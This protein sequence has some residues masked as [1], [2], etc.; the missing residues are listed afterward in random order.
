MIDDAAVIK[1]QKKTI[2]ELERKLY[3]MNNGNDNNNNNETHNVTAMK[4]KYEMQINKLKSICMNPS[5]S[6]SD[7]ITDSNN[8]KKI[9]VLGKRRRHSIALECNGSPARK[10]LKTHIMRNLPRVRHASFSTPMNKVKCE[11]DDYECKLRKQSH[12]SKSLQQELYAKY[13]DFNAMQEEIDG[14]N[15]ENKIYIQKI[16]FYE[17]N[18]NIKDKDMIM[19]NQKLTLKVNELNCELM[20]YKQKENNNQVDIEDTLN[21]EL[22]VSKETIFQLEEQIRELRLDIERQHKF[23]ESI[24]ASSVEVSSD[25]SNNNDVLLRLGLHKLQSKLILIKNDKKAINQ[26]LQNEKNKFILFGEECNKKLIFYNEFVNKKFEELQN[27]LSECEDEKRLFESQYHQI[28]EERDELRDE[29]IVLRRP[30]NEIIDELQSELLTIQQQIDIDTNHFNNTQ[31][32]LEN[33][34]VEIE[35]LKQL[36]RELTKS[37]NEREEMVMNE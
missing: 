12:I 11:R 18:V 6:L 15:E 9:S 34:L 25:M 10:R 29:I 16:E 2:A 35:N 17:S 33:K 22:E 14:L 19:E 27:K 13:K 37:M 32:E 20:K 21:R 3:H 4:E 36:N 30:E 5:H 23:T 31:N 28:R 26:I 8:N 1:Q 24:R 7:I